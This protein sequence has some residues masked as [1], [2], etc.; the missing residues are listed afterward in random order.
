M[1]CSNVSIVQAS[2]VGWTC[3]TGGLGIKP[4]A[5]LLSLRLETSYARGCVAQ[6]KSKA[7]Y[8]LF[9]NITLTA[10]IF[11]GFKSTSQGTGVLQAQ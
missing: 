1:K 11:S 2:L 7:H 4:H 3:Q 8:W 5:F 6:A 9:I 10:H